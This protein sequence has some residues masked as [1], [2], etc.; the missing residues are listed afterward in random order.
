MHTSNVNK[1]RGTSAMT[2]A[3]IYARVSTDDQHTDMQVTELQAVAA[4]SGW[5]VIDVKVEKIS[6]L[7]RRASRPALDETLKAI[8]QGKADKLLV[9]SVDRLGRSMS[10]LL[11]T[12]ETIKAAN[13]HLYIHQ[14]AIDTATPAGEAMFGMLSVFSQFEKATA[15][16]R[17]RSGIEAAKARGVRFG[18]PKRVVSFTQRQKIVKLKAEGLS[19][20]EIGE[21]VK[22]NHTRVRAELMKAERAA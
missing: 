22:L 17:Q 12:L 13:G 7:K 18:R 2:T 19:L 11:N 1:L 10:D 4:R 15:A 8:T 21:Q 5:N 14:S 6:G 16:S 3:I 9:W 20:R